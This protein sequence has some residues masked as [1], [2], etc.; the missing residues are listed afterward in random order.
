MIRSSKQA[1]THGGVYTVPFDVER[2]AEMLRR[3]IFSLCLTRPK[4]ETVSTL[5]VADALFTR[6]L[7]LR[8]KPN[9][10]HI[11]ILLLASEIPKT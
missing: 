10:E 3:Q 6:L 1:A 9:L 5:L 11:I 4:I 2:F 7:S 8:A